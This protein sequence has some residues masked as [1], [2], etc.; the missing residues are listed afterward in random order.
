MW[1]GC[2]RDFAEWNPVP[3]D[4]RRLGG[5]DVGRD[6]TLVH[7]NTDRAERGVRVVRVGC[8]RGSRA[9]TRPRGA[10]RAANPS[11]ADE[12]IDERVIDP[13]GAD[14]DGAAR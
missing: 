10:D 3:V 6:D 11:H 13:R 14:P 7:G 9:T 2:L 8:S 5:P 4:E 12:A 1:P